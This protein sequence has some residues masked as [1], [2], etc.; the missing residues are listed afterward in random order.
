M[1]IK[2][3]LDASMHKSV[4]HHID[5]IKDKNAQLYLNIDKNNFQIERIIELSKKFTDLEIH[6]RRFVSRSFFSDL[7]NL[8]IYIQ[9]NCTCCSDD[10][11]YG[12]DIIKSYNGMDIHICDTEIFFNRPCDPDWVESQMK[13]KNIP[14][15][16]IDAVVL[17]FIEDGYHNYDD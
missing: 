8:E 17:K 13:K 1:A 4:I 2:A 12:I 6:K 7:E 5:G 10:V 16:I 15:D 14:E 3:K 9:K 11:G